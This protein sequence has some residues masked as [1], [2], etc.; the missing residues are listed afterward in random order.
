MIGLLGERERSVSYTHLDVYKRQLICRLGDKYFSAFVGA[1]AVDYF[2]RHNPTC[3]YAH[4]TSIE[5]SFR[6]AIQVIDSR[7]LVAL[8]A[9][10]GSTNRG[11]E[12]HELRPRVDD[13]LK[14]L[15]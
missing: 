4:P 9:A 6:N 5:R 2:R 3:L 7:P 12:L 14:N 10:E 13:I 15:R 11:R 1:D 8:L